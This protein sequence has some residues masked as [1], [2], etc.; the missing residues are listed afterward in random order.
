[1]VEKNS[2]FNIS[3][4]LQVF[5]VVFMLLAAPNPLPAQAQVLPGEGPKRVAI[6]E[7]EY[8]SYQWW[9]LSWRTSQV[10]CQVYTE[11]ETLPDY[12]QVKYFCGDQIAQQWLNSGPCTDSERNSSQCNGLY[13]HMA[14]STPATRK[15]EVNLPPAEVFVSIASCNPLPGSKACTTLPYLRLEAVEP[16]PNEQI[17]Q[18]IGT[19]GGAA[20]TCPGGA[21]DLPL[22]PSGVQGTEVTFMAQS[23]YG[24]QSE[25]YTAQV[26]VIPWGDFADPEAASPDKPSYYVDVLSSQ[27]R[28]EVSSSCSTVWQAFQPVDGPPPWLRTPEL[29]SD[30]VS[31][32]RYYYLAGSLIK[33]GLVDARSCPDGGVFS[34]GS[35]SECGMEA[36]QPIVDQW[37]NQFDSEIIRVAQDTGLPA[38]MMKNIFS[39]ESQFWPGI[40]AK[41]YEAGLG[42]L[43]DVGADAVLL[44]NPSFYDQFCPLV[45]STQTCQ[46]GFGNLDKEQQ[47]MLRGAL[48]QKVNA[49]CPDCPVGVDLTQANFSISVFA[50]SML[51]NC[52]QV[53]QI[54]FNSTGRMAG[55]VAAYEDLWKFTLLNYNAGS[56]CLATSM[57]RTIDQGLALNWAN[58]SA[59]LEPACQPGVSYVED[60]SSI[61]PSTVS[62]IGALVATPKPAVY[63]P[64][65]TYVG[66]VYVLPTRL[67][68]LT[69]TATATPYFTPTPTLT[70]TPTITPTPPAFTPSPTATQV[71]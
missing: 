33:Q 60:I 48:V 37:Q 64:T 52:E 47:Q 41:V 71:P 25:N 13:L 51:A 16:L 23:S 67:P 19:Y 21:C 46:R 29:A 30:L 69:P 54:V 10:V 38:Q 35:A 61:P 17:I 7:V 45:L 15:V 36:A 1:M 5:L 8:R 58:L 68:T 20:F 57:K 2:K 34:S 56:G 11:H 12:A 59:N 26:R 3:K 32:N 42:H 53:G 65:P 22:G 18:I 63:L 14:G 50:R 4:I 49:Q 43:S 28:G 6:I 31:R 44:W 55:Q 24:D 66:T 9:L 62:G 70:P 40:Y 27:W 39:R